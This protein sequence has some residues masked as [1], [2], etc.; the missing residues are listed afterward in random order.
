MLD[1][2][3]IKGSDLLK[4]SSIDRKVFFFGKIKF[5]FYRKKEIHIKERCF[6][7]NENNSLCLK[8]T[9]SKK[10]GISIFSIEYKNIY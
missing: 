10:F 1:R 5:L 8:L 6:N 2:S 3:R 7:L 9:E 4:N